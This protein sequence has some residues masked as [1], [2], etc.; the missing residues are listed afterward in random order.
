[1]ADCEYSYEITGQALKSMTIEQIAEKW[2]IS[3]DTLL[4]GIMD[5]FGLK[6]NYN[7]GNLLDDLRQEYRFRPAEIKV[8]AENI[9]S[10]L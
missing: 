4:I 3:A 7:I 8:I 1:M 2:E 6:G 9:K 5:A 10:T